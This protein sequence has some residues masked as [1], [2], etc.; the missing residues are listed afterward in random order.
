[1][2]YNHNS[3]V[4]HMSENK[5]NKQHNKRLGPQYLSPSDN[6]VLEM[7]ALIL[8]TMHTPGEKGPTFLERVAKSGSLIS[9]P[10]HWMIGRSRN[11]GI[12]LTCGA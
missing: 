2:L 7:L 6:T 9:R 11:E 1:M 5:Q 12:G 8:S 4:V 3:I 10:S